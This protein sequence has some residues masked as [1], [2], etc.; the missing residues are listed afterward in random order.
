M[1]KRLLKLFIFCEFFLVFPVAICSNTWPDTAFNDRGSDFLPL[2]ERLIADGFDRR[3]IDRLYAH[4][5]IRFLPQIVKR[6]ITYREQDLNYSQFLSP[7]SI[8]M[9]HRYLRQYKVSLCKAQKQ[10]GVSPEVIVSLLLVE[11][12]LGRYMGKYPVLNVLS[13]LALS[14][15]EK[16][17]PFFQCG[18]AHDINAQTKKALK[19]KAEWAYAELKAFLRYAMR[20]DLDPFSIN[21]SF[22]GAFGIPQ[23]IPSS[24]LKY[25]RDGDGDECVDLYS[26]RDAIMSVGN[27]LKCCGWKESLSRPEKEGILLR[28]NRSRYYVETVMDLSKRLTSD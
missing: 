12:R 13:S 11:T 7:R 6:Y 19:R 14:G 21:G 27:Y 24:L 10:Y 16:I 8:S 18:I 22:A 15:M 1:K 2:K 23:F 20:D 28:Y 17:S 26:H 9:S 25:G 3:F 5:Q 4:P